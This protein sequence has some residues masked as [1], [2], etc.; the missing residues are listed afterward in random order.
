MT[1]PKLIDQ[2]IDLHNAGDL[3]G[4]ARL[5]DRILRSAPNHADA[6]HLRGLIAYQRG[7]DVRAVELIGRAVAVNGRLVVP[8]NHLGMALLRLGRLEDA[9]ASFGHALAL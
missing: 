2:A 9:A 5:Y 7:D 8:H 3:D 1:N 6:L 4:A